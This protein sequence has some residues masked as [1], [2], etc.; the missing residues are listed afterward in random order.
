ME[1]ELIKEISEILPVILVL[2]QS[3]GKPADAFSNYLED[4]NLPV[5]AVQ[6]VMSEPYE[7]IR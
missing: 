7:Y 3:I 2:T 1:I 5:A 4:M 6:N